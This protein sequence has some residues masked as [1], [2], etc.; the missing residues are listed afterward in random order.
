MLIAVTNGFGAC[1]LVATT[2]GDEYQL[3]FLKVMILAYDD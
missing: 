3:A 2:A 1:Q